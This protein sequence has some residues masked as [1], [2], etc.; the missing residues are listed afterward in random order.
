MHT[1]PRT[2]IL[3]RFC[4]ALLALAAVLLLG[5]PASA[6]GVVYVVP[7][8]AGT[9][10][11]TSWANAKDL[12]AAL[13]AANSGD[14]LWVKAGTY[15]PTTTSD[16]TATFTLKSGVALYGGF[17]GAETQRSQRNWTTNVT[18]LSGAIGTVNNTSDNSYHVVVGSLVDSTAVLDGFT[19]TGGSADAPISELSADHDGGGMLQHQRQALP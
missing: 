13:T 6:T 5:Q 2:R 1:Q 12:A 16:R 17:A 7:G 8:G 11:G 18:I 4:L 14:E 9:K 19:I 3:V 10:D 15:K